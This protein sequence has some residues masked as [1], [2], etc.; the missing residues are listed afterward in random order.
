MR[1]PPV[2]LMAAAVLSL[3]GCERNRYTEGNRADV[4]P[5]QGA[6]SD[7][8]VNLGGSIRSSVR[9]EDSLSRIENGFLV[10]ETHVRNTTGR[11]IP[12][13]W[14]TVFQDKEGFDLPVTSNPWAPVVINSNETV[15][16]RKTAPV[17][18]GVKATFYIREAAP[19]RK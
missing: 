4:T 9:I 1:T 3:A 12:C 8:T 10:V 19:I 15:P 6:K 11:N 5:G 13:E 17:T 7:I 2:L 18:G 14:R 16:L